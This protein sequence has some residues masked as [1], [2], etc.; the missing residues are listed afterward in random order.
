MVLR[1]RVTASIRRYRCYSTPAIVDIRNSLSSALKTAM[2]SR[3][4]LTTITIRSVLADIYLADKASGK[5]VQAPAIISILRKAVARRNDSASQFAL[6]VRP[7]LAEKEHREANLLLSFLPPL[8]SQEEIDSALN[9]AI[10][11][12]PE[13]DRKIPGKIFKAFYSTVDRSSVDAELVKKRVELL[14]NST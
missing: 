12:I 1:F 11:A 7:D 3:D 10:T 5:Q 9:K 6:A 4:A 13:K 2:K 8:L 14:L